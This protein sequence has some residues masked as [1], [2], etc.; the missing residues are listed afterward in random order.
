MNN[1]CPNCGYEY[2][3]FDIYCSRCGAKIVK[4]DTPKQENL[5]PTLFKSSEENKK[6]NKPFRRFEFF[7]SDLKN[8]ENDMMSNF[9]I[10]LL[11]ACFVVVGCIYFSLNKYSEQKLILKY[12]N[13][14]NNPQQIPELKEP[15]QYNDLLNNLYDVEVFL[16]LYL[17]YSNDSSEKKEQVFNSFINEMDKLPHI[18]NESILKEDISGCGGVL[19]PSKVKSCSK[20]LNKKFKKTGILVYS[21]YNTL[22]LYPDYKF[23]QK[24]YS[25]YLSYS[26]NEYLKIRAKYNTP[27]SVGLKL[28]IKPKKLADKIYAFENFANASKNQDL[29]EKAFNILYIDFRKFIFSPEI[30]ATTTQEMKKEFKNAYNYYL[31]KNKNSALCS[32]I[33]SY[34][35][36]KRSYSEENFKNDYP[37]PVFEINF[38]E[39][40]ESSILS[41]VFAQLR[42]NIFSN[43]ADLRCFYV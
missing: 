16:K 13:Y 6:E 18:T 34:L 36:K 12:K 40:V 26:L 29:Q 35:D 25:D 1:K 22:Y 8:N 42:K 4:E 14:M 41:D 2:G 17:K 37:Y 5:E 43:I 24:K 23:I 15:N 32:V 28:Y 27:T 7:N 19:S 31:R 9:I 11:V 38:E 3:E 21:D 20:E 30:Y 39:N 10:F 33:M